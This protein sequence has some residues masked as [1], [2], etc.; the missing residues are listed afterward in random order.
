[1][2]VPMKTESDMRV[3]PVSNHSDDIVGIF[4]T[5]FAHYPNRI[6]IHYETSIVDVKYLDGIYTL[7][8]KHAITHTSDILCLT[9]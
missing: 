6:T 9:T 3:F 8:D 2:G 4:E 5:L 1:M 7:V